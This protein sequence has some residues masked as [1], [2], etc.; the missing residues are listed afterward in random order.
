MDIEDLAVCGDS[1]NLGSSFDVTCTGSWGGGMR[2]GW[3]NLNAFSFCF[4]HPRRER[5]WSR[6]EGNRWES[7]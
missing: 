6:I 4:V 1:R 2:V 3:D 7:N 5:A